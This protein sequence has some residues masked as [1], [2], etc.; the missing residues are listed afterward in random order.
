MKKNDNEN[1]DPITYVP[2]TESHGTKDIWKTLIILGAITLFDIILYFAMPHSMFRNWVFIFFGI[3]KAYY[4]VGSF[5]HLK[6]EKFELILIILVPM[7]LI[8]ALVAGM[9]H[10]GNFW[11]QFK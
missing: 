5:M 8:I 11:L 2:H 4:I 7:V 6:N 9:L 1:Y 10:D 3:V